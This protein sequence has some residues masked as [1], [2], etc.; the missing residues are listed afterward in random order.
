MSMRGMSAFRKSEALSYVWILAFL[1]RFSICIGLVLACN[2]GVETFSLMRAVGNDRVSIVSLTAVLVL[3]VVSSA[4]AIY[5]S[6]L[7]IIYLLVI[8]K[9]ISH[10][11]CMYMILT[12]FSSA[13]WLLYRLLMF[14][15][16]LLLIPLF[17]LWIRQLC[18]RSA[19]LHRNVILCLTISLF[20]GALDYFV[21]SP[22]IITLMNHY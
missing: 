4:A 6:H 10:G 17:Y 20:A 12:E 3:P 7:G 16:S 9:G 1:W 2:L 21:I 14:S 15:D 18:D 22:Y 11:F 19:H 13:A 8:G 5:F